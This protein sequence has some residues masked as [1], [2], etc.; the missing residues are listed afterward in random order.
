MS[1]FHVKCKPSDLT[2]KLELSSGLCIHHVIS[3]I[4]LEPCDEDSW[5]H[6]LP[7][8]PRP[9]LIDG[10]KQ[11]EI[12]QIIRQ[13]ADQCLLAWKGLDEFTWEPIANLKQDAPEMLCTFQ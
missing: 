10:I 3:V 1:P 5:S 2:Y 4:H 6:Q 9:A 12:K 11:Y 13:E 8:K 7:Q